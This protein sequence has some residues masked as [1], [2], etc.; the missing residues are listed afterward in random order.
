MLRWLVDKYKDVRHNGEPAI[1]F[2]LETGDAWLIISKVVH[3]AFDDQGSPEGT[4]T[5]QFQEGE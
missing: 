2:E 1:M 3:I 5:F 4:E